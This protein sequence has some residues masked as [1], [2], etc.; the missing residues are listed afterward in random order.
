MVALGFQPR[1]S[2]ATAGALKHYGT[3]LSL[4]VA[5]SQR[6]GKLSQDLE[7]VPSDPIWS[8]TLEFFL[9]LWGQSLSKQLTGFL[10]YIAIFFRF[11]PDLYG[12]GPLVRPPRRLPRAQQCGVDRSVG[13]RGSALGPLGWTWEAPWKSS[14]Q[15]GL[16]EETQETSHPAPKP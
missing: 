1:G 12:L 15:M 3:L 10:G 5:H 7:N 14:A 4:K 11:K 2:P 6:A 16:L 8:L 13:C 9:E